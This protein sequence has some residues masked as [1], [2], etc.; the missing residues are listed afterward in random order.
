MHWFLE[1]H[2]Y[3]KNKCDLCY[4][5]FP[6]PCA[7]FWPTCTPSFIESPVTLKFVASFFK[8]SESHLLLHFNRIL[9]AILFFWFQQW[10]SIRYMH[11]FLTSKLWNALICMGF[12]LH[13]FLTSIEILFP[14]KFL[15]PFLIMNSSLFLEF[16]CNLINHSNKIG[17]Y[18]FVSL[19]WIYSGSV[20]EILLCFLWMYC[21]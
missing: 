13:I 4:I 11:Y 7:P 5:F 20:S 15:V 9:N 16:W 14:A 10:V 3:K 21:R 1:R 17:Y 6:I 2:R 8:I 18:D 12:L 19:F